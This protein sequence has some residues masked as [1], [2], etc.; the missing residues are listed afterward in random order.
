MMLGISSSFVAFMRFFLVYSLLLFRLFTMFKRLV[1]LPSHSPSMLLIVVSLSGLPPSPLFLS[2]ILIIFIAYPLANSLF[3]VIF[4]VL[5]SISAISYV[6]FC[7]RLF[8]F[9]LRV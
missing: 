4:L 1:K 3:L 6:S 5:S 2:K 7:L 9:K 8:A